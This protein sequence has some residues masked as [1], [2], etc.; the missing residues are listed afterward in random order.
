MKLIK[1]VNST[2][3]CNV[4]SPFELRRL[5]KMRSPSQNESL[6]FFYS[7]RLFTRWMCRDCEMNQIIS[8]NTKSNQIW[9]SLIVHSYGAS[10]AVLNSYTSQPFSITVNFD[11]TEKD[12]G[13]SKKG[14]KI[15]TLSSVLHGDTFE[16]GVNLIPVSIIHQKAIL[17]VTQL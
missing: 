11:A 6:A 3:K 1:F 15:G 17:R 5:L 13:A 12:N 8:C 14:L 9:L 16:C 4:N 10:C 7:C 2:V